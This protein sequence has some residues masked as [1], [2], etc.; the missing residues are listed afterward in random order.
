MLEIKTIAM[1]KI[2]S[3]VVLM[4]FPMLLIA[5]GIQFEHGTFNEALKKAKAENKLLFIDGYAVWCGPCKKM[6]T[7]VFL[8]KEVGQYFDKNLIALKVDVE[9]GEG[10]AIKRKYGISGLPGY[11]FIDGDGNVVY[12]FN[13]AMPTAK[14]MEEV[15]LAVS[16]AQDP[17]SVGRM[18]EGYELKKNDEKFVRSYLDKLKESK[19]T[20]YTEV[21]EQYLE[22]QKSVAETTKEMVV[23]LA[24]HSNEIVFG[25]MA[26]KI[27]QN[28][29]GS[30]AWK[31]FVRKDIREAFQKLQKNM[32][33]NTTDYAVAKKDTTLLELTI[34]RAIRSGVKVDDVQRKKIYIFYYLQTEEGS[35]YK[36][37]VQKDNEAYINSIDVKTVRNQYLDWKKNTEDGK[38]KGVTPHAD[39]ISNEIANM[40]QSYARFAETDQEKKDVI[41]WMKVGYD[42]VPGN[43]SI[44]STY[45]TLLYLFN[46]NKAEA[47][48]IK[49]EAYQIANQSSG[50]NAEGIKADIEIMKA[51]KN[52][53]LK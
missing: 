12:R 7:T 16:Y 26:D 11:V 40:V 19:S 47:I 50:K 24:D 1:K 23:L 10:P 52:I 37:L 8:E 42:I 39:R 22:I 21:L 9:R 30:E 43:T 38:I 41:R 33:E 3:L 53:Y 28:N 49:E 20:N 5:Q 18:A 35:K 46:N 17:N 51:G 36:A 29:L 2:Y 6:A 15:K 44:M 25:G 32:I 13:A 45:A 34:D 14:F 4:L 31:P 48:A 27:V